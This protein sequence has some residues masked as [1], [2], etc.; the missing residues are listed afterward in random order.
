MRECAVG[1]RGERGVILLIATGIIFVLLA[2]LGLAFDVG[3]LQWSRRR[4]QTAADAGALDGAWAKAAG[5]SVTAKGQDGAA[6]NGFTDGQNGVTVTINSPPTLG[7][8]TG[9]ATA[10]EAIVTQDAP[11]FFMRVL[12]WSTLPVRARAV[13]KSGYDTACVFALDPHAQDALRFTGNV[14]LT[15]GCGVVS[16]SDDSNRATRISGGPTIT[17]T[18]GASI[19]SVGG[20]TASGSYTMN[21][22]TS[23]DSGINSPG[24][25]LSTQAMPTNTGQPCYAGAAGM[26]TG[27]CT[28][29]HNVL[30]T[31]GNYQPGVYCGGISINGGDNAH[32]DPGVY[33]LVGRPGLTINTTGTVSGTG[34][35][36]YLTDTT[37]G[38]SPV[39]PCA[40]LNG[41][42]GNGGSI[43]IASQATISLSAPTDGAYAGM[44][45]ME[46]RA[47]TSVPDSVINGG[48]G[49]TL[50]GAIYLPHTNLSFSG[51]SDSNGYM[52]LL[53]NT[54]TFAGNTTLRLPDFPAEFINNNPAFKKW[55][56]MAE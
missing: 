9:D 2:F 20:Y 29:N 50:N 8:Y 45:I 1:R 52:M 28:D 44:L 51:T 31:G 47:L 10:V 39:W 40:G 3:Y 22:S 56:T 21:P 54:V 27:P 17:M 33:I 37:T 4:A 7:A 12:N 6:M 46:N 43:S 15:F 16:E 41:S 49:C 23:L 55:V 13:A 42:S 34:V 11:S 32:F 14:N 30:P 38:V 35:T 26:V 48:A 5:G 53:A 19:G 25:P 24:D 18:N 36:F